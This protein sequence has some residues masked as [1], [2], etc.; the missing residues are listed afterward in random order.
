MSGQAESVEDR[1]TESPRPRHLSLFESKNVKM[2]VLMKLDN[3]QKKGRKDVGVQYVSPSRQ[4]HIVKNA[5]YHYVLTRAEIATKP[6]MDNN[7]L[8]C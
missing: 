3:G 7:F 4:I 2:S 6:T 1:Q 5:M 8:Q